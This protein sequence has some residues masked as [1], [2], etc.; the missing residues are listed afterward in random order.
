[1]RRGTY[2]FIIQKQNVLKAEYQSDEAFATQI[3]STN[4]ENDEHEAL[5]SWDMKRQKLK[6][7]PF[8]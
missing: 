7:Q 1:M 4:N 2:I 6:F 5:T 3:G 8:E